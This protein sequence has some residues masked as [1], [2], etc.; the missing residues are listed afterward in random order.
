MINALEKDLHGSLLKY[1]YALGILF[2]LNHFTVKKYLAWNL[3]YT[4]Q[5]IDGLLEKRGAKEMPSDKFKQL[6]D[7][8]KI[9]LPPAAFYQFII[10]LSSFEL[11]AK[12]E[13]L[14]YARLEKDDFIERR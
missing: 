11:A 9:Y 10:A 8:V 7:I 14:A 3:V 5:S 4:A 13:I 6:V 2:G 12:K 1:L